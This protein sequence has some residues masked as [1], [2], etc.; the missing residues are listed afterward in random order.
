MSS[1]TGSDAARDWSAAVTDSCEPDSSTREAQVSDPSIS[2]VLQTVL[3]LR[4]RDLVIYDAVSS[5]PGASTKELANEVDRDRSNV[6]RSLTRLDDAGLVCR[7]RHLLNQ[8][9]Y[10]YV[11]YAESGEVV[12]DRLTDA[13]DQWTEAAMSTIETRW[14]EG[15]S[16]SV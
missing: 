2:A 9:G 1:G 6:N 4:S 12:R 15:V 8:G 13:L 5:Q 16:S 10:F 11:Y 14:D 3:G 7:Q